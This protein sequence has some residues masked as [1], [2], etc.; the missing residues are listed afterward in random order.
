MSPAGP[1]KIPESEKKFG[2]DLS[3]QLSFC[4]D[5]PVD[6]IIGF[7]ESND[8]EETV[9]KIAEILDDSTYVNYLGGLMVS[10]VVHPPD[11]RLK[12]TTIAAIDKVRVITPNEPLMPIEPIVPFK[13]PKSY[14]Q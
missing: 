11:V 3:A 14:F 2:P 6:V 10:A 13:I 8:N 9:K 1:R 5:E 7:T 4:P 12:L